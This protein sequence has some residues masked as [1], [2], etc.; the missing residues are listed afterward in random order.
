MR[1]LQSGIGLLLAAVWIAPLCAQEPTGTIRGRITDQSS[2][3]PLR[4]ATVRVGTRIAET[5][6]DGGYL[7][8]DIPAGTDTLRVSMIGY[9]PI[10]QAVNPDEQ[11]LRMLAQHVQNTDQGIDM[12]PLPPP[13]A[14]TLEGPKAQQPTPTPQNNQPTLGPP[15]GQAPPR[16]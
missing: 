11:A 2:Q 5:R 1:L 9:T 10:A 7:L 13:L 12:P 3:L 15:L 4:G 16:P 6:A 14:E 8:A